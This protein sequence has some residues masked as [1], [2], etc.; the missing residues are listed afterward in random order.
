MQKIKAKT[1]QTQ[2]AMPINCLISTNVMRLIGYSKKKPKLKN[3]RQG[4]PNNDTPSVLNQLSQNSSY[5]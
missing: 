1:S 2:T 3:K 5:N 4:Q